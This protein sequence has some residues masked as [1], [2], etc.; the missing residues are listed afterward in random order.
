MATELQTN[1]PLQ[2][3]RSTDSAGAPG[4]HNTATMELTL[5]IG[6]MTCAS[7]VRRIERALQKVE[8]V[9]EAGVNLATERATIKYDPAVATID[10]LKAAVEKAGYTV[11]TEEASLPI[12]GMTC[13]SCV[14]HV[15][16]S[17]AKLPGVESVAVNLATEHATVKYNPAMVSTGDFRQAVER[18]GYAIRADEQAQE[19]GYARAVASAGVEAEPVDRERERRQ[20]EIKDLRNKFAVSLVAALVIMVGMFLPTSLLPWSMQV[21]YYAM[22]NTPVYSDQGLR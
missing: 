14:R 21:R 15:E 2:P 18:A 13:A 12:E 22:Y 6:G 10:N 9:S 20:R 11:R 3:Q 4:T 1:I 8:G 7:C 19:L 17:L 16:K 5:P